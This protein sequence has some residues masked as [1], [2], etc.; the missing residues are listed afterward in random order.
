MSDIQIFKFEN[1]NIRMVKEEDGSIW[2]VAKD[3]CD[4]LN[5]SKPANAYRRVDEVDIKETIIRSSEEGTSQARRL[6]IVN[7]SGLYSLVFQGKTDASKRFKR[8]LT[9]EV[10]PS[11]RKTGSYSI[12]TS[13]PQ[14]K[15]LTAA[16]QL[17][18]SAQ[19]LVELE[20]RQSLIDEKVQVQDKRLVEIE[21]RVM[22][23]HNG[24]PTSALG[25]LR[26]KNFPHDSHTVNAFGRMA[27]K[28]ANDLGVT[29]YKVPDTRFGSVN[30]FYED[31]YDLVAE[32]FF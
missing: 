13:V 1:N 6:K 2:W 25:Y 8:W 10:I 22:G 7:E 32:E 27:S 5:L 21:S 15:P 17:L 18:Q 19:A 16:Q 29:K 23:S 20:E 3:V 12:K 31:F 30:A 11:I 4:A 9:S 28:M 24:Q 14:L 26:N